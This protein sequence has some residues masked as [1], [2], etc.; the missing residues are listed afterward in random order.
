[1]T[2]IHGSEYL[3]NAIDHEE[4]DSAAMASFDKTTASQLE[5]GDARSGMQEALRMISADLVKM[6]VV[7]L[8]VKSFVGR[9]S[10]DEPETEELSDNES[11]LNIVIKGAINSID[12]IGL[13]LTY[14]SGEKRTIQISGSNI[15]ESHT[16]G[17]AS[18]MEY[19]RR[20]MEALNKQD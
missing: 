15:P 13:T 18:P 20:I 10:L 11:K 3:I 14:S 8:E 4:G 1:M 6:G 5:G 17:S 16:S 9:L 2:K 19:T 12:L 7:K